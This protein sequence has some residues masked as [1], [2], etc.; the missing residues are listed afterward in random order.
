VVAEAIARLEALHDAAGSDAIRRLL[1]HRLVAVGIEG[2]TAR[3][4][5]EF[6]GKFTVIATGGLAPMFDETTD[7]ID[8][9]DLDLTLRGLYAIHRRN[10]PVAPSAHG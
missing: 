5:Q 4:S 9:C 7:V 2:I 6:G 3:I 8:H 1:N 10:R